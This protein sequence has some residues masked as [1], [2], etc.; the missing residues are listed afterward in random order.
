[1][2][3][4]VAHV[5]RFLL[6]RAYRPEAVAE[7]SGDAAAFHVR[8]PGWRETP[9]R[10]LDGVAAELGLAGV[11]LKDESDRLGLPAFKVLGASW[12]VERALREAPDTRTLVAASAGNHGR[13]VAHVA[14]MRGLA[15]RIFVPARAAA[16]RRAA[17]ESEGAE[18]VVTDGDYE[19]AVARATEAAAEP[20]AL[21]IADVGDSG[22][23]HWVIDGY[24]TLF[25]EAAA[26]AGFDALLVPAGVGSFAAA[27]ARYGALAGKA[28][29]AIEPDNAACLGASL[30]AGEPTAVPTPGTRMAGMDCAE[31][32]PAAWPSLRDG[33]LGTVGVSD[34]E[35][36]AAMRELA[37]L[38]Y[39]IGDC[40]AAP[41][42]ALRAVMTQDDG[43]ALRAAAGLDEARARVLLV[44][45]EGVT[46][47]D[48]YAAAMGGAAA[49]G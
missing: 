16:G 30:A 42:A 13:A 45:T 17:I 2:A 19:D 10:Q 43:A 1:M 34:E 7:P 28:V 37:A 8:L 38:G 27:A 40:G 14:A 31:V 47:P 33:I 49:A 12:A 23:A 26:Q 20:G 25:A 41:L 11:A 44:A 22:A 39:A 4:S 48:G 18:L 29:I 32:S 15:C 24:H 5:P 3:G 46:D 6:N 21:G 35:A 36:V 9:V